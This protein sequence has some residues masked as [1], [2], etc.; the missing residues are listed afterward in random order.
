MATH[1]LDWE[2][3]M[4]QLLDAQEKAG[5]LFEAVGRVG[6]LQAGVSDSVA[7]DAVRDLAAERLLTI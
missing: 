4:A 7:S 5:E 2:M 1:E 6:I 3:R